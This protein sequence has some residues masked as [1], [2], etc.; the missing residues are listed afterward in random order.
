[1]RTVPSNYTVLFCF[2]LLDII[3]TVSPHAKMSKVEHTNVFKLRAQITGL[4]SFTSSILTI[5]PP[6]HT[7]VAC[8]PSYK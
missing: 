2:K 1:M 6:Q 8:L 3:G 4:Y 7:Q 5:P